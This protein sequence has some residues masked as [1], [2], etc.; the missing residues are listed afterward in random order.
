VRAAAALAAA[1]LLAGCGG[2]DESELL[3]FAAASLAEVAPAV[4]AN[5]TL[6]TGGS[7]D[8]AAQ[9]RDGA[10]ADVFLSAS[11]EPLDELRDRG[12]VAEPEAFAANRLVIVVPAGNPSGA[13]ELADLDRAGMKLVLGAEGVPVGDYARAALASAGLEEALAQVVSFEDDVRGV[14]SKVALGEADAGIVY[15]TDVEAAAE[16]VL[17]LPIPDEHQ[18]PVRYYAAAVAPASAEARAYLAKLRG[19]DGQRALRAAG[20]VPLEA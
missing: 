5:A 6:V 2:G 3:V 20:F 4:D 7:N 11:L 15:A 19:A 10:N 1:V 12:L 8:L 9:I 18:P 13:H 17:A 14:L 16:D